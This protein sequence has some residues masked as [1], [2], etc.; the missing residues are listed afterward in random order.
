M[1]TRVDMLKE[2][3]DNLR[4]RYEDAEEALPSKD[5]FDMLESLVTIV[6]ELESKV[7]GINERLKAQE[8]VMGKKKGG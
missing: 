5:M 4:D 7:N 3:I 6:E 1:A 8:K 2:K